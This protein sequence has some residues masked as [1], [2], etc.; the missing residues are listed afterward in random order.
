V[1]FH[2]TLAIIRDLYNII[3]VEMQ[4]V[5]EMSILNLDGHNVHN[6]QEDLI[7]IAN[8]IQISARLFVSFTNPHNEDVED[9]KTRINVI[10]SLLFISHKHALMT[11]FF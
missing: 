4:T 8:I 11:K 2:M 1:D 6:Y 9:L 10:Q 5:S 3:K 7:D